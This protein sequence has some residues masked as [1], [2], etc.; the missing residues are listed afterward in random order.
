MNANDLKGFMGSFAIL[1]EIGKEIDKIE[2]NTDSLRKAFKNIIS[3]IDK[4]ETL[5]KD[6]KG[7]VLSATVL[8]FHIRY[9]E[10]N[11]IE[12][13]TLLNTLGE[14]HIEHFNKALANNPFS[15]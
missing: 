5:P 8:D 2:N 13:Q 12:L 4:D 6:L 3:I 7:V 11:N 1:T 15:R 9:S 14:Y 10:D